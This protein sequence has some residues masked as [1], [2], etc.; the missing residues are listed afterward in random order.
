M[1]YLLLMAILI[2]II[3]GIILLAGGRIIWGIALIL[4]GIALFW[5]MYKRYRSR[6]RNSCDCMPDIPC[7]ECDSPDCLDCGGHS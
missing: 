1:F 4:A 7:L 5:F 3:A 6:V 2:C